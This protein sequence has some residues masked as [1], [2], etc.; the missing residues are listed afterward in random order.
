MAGQ[1]EVV[2]GGLSC[3][4]ARHESAPTIASRSSSMDA[5]AYFVQPS[6]VLQMQMDMEQ[7]RQSQQHAQGQSSSTPWKAA[8]GQSIECTAS[9]NLTA[10]WK[11]STADPLF[12]ALQTM[13]TAVPA[14]GVKRSVLQD[15]NCADSPSL[16]R[17][18]YESGTTARPPPTPIPQSPPP[19]PR[20]QRAATAHAQ[21]ATAEPAPSPPQ[22][23]PPP[24]D[25]PCLTR[26][27]PASQASRGGAWAA[28]GSVAQAP[29]WPQEP[30]CG[31]GAHSKRGHHARDDEGARKGMRLSP[32][33]RLDGL[34]N[35]LG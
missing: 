14:R 26:H 4:V 15:W 7:E 1:M 16:K 32:P 28:P 13:F 20:P 17:F 8:Q 27:R 6:P 2:G 10:Q 5:D 18:R 35:R 23:S 24:Y 30:R 12:R 9:A 11:A 25:A 31:A 34:Q 29:Q 21:A 3:L 22:R 19:I 33:S